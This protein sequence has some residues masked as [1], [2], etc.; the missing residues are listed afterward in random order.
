MSKFKTLI[1]ASSLK[2]PEA[3]ETTTRTADA[4][5]KALATVVKMSVRKGGR[6]WRMKHKPQEAVTI[7][8][9]AKSKA[10]AAAVTPPNTNIRTSEG[11]DVSSISAASATMTTR[12]S[13]P[14]KK[15]KAEEA[16]RT[17]ADT[18]SKALMAAAIQ[19]YSK[20]PHKTQP[21]KSLQKLT[22]E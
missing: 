8:V 4:K 14:P 11:L 1:L 7:I 3:E 19:K 13:K 5:K 16:A 12:A 20:R 21:K 15:P 9:E 17:T 2:K 6:K 10:L 18:K 22:V